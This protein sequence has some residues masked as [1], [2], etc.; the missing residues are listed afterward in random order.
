MT[1]IR[2]LMR[3]QEILAELL[4]IALPPKPDASD[5]EGSLNWIKESHKTLALSIKK[6]MAEHE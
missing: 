6:W 3:E 4:G 1:D 5:E 2:I